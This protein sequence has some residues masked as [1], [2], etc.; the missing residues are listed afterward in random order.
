MGSPAVLAKARDER[1][2][3]VVAAIRAGELLKDGVIADEA[4]GKKREPGLTVV[5]R[6]P[7]MLM[8]DVTPVPEAEQ[9]RPM[10][11]QRDRPFGESAGRRHCEAAAL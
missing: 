9:F 1:E 7:P 3:G 8:L 11:K 6:Q 10:T 2:M 5:A 4:A